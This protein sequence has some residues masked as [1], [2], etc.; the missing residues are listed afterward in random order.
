VI[1]AKDI[2]QSTNQPWFGVIFR[3]CGWKSSVTIRYFPSLQTEIY[4]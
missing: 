2:N 3:P 4:S 1:V